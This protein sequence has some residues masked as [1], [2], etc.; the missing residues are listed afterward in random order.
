[1]IFEYL[2][3]FDRS[4]FT[5][6][7]KMNPNLLLMLDQARHFAEIPFV[8]TSSFR[9]RTHNTAVGGATNSSH[10]DGLAVDIACSNS[11]DRFTIVHA[12]VRAGF[13]R[14][15]IGQHHIHCDIDVEKG[16]D[17]IWLE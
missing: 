14:I 5:E 2:T 4:E 3:Y 6:P 15:G 16:F 10:L 17:V 7:E 8:I 11:F 13:K 9:D 12:L 1:M